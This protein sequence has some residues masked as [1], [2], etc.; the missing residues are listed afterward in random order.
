MKIRTPTRKHVTFY[1]ANEIPVPL[2]PDSGLMINQPD[3]IP[4][5]QVASIFDNTFVSINL[6]SPS[7]LDNNRTPLQ[8]RLLRGQSVKLTTHLYLV[9]RLGMHGGLH[10]S[11]SPKR[12]HGVALQRQ[13]F[14]VHNMN[15]IAYI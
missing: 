4:Y 2:F 5:T 9:S 1:E 13:L 3:N 15:Y 11:T 12:N 14:I 7:K 10:Q 8:S 6:N